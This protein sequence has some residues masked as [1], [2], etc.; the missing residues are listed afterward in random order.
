LYDLLDRDQPARWDLLY[1]NYAL[2]T[3]EVHEVSQRGGIT[4]A[5]LRVTR[6]R[7]QI[8]SLMLGGDRAY[9]D[10]MLLEPSAKT[11]REQNLSAP[12]T[13]RVSLFAY[14]LRKCSNVRRQW[15][16]QRT[17]QDNFVI[18]D[19]LHD[20]LLSPINRA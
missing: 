16:L 9:A 1:G 5:D 4:A 12:G 15:T 14:P 10:G 17:R 3:Q 2:A 11:R 20:W 13:P 7:S 18:D 19:Q 6:T 8:S